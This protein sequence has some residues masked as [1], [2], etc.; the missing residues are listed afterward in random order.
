MALILLS[1]SSFLW[2]VEVQHFA[3]SADNPWPLQ[4][5]SVLNC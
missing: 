1:L 4:V 5:M 3:P 2:P